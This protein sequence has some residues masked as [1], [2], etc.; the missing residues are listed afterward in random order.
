MAT[1]TFIDR[2]RT[3][4]KGQ[5]TG[6]AMEEVVAL[7]P[8]LTWNQVFLAIDDLSRS[9]EIRVTLDADR[10]YRIQ[11]HRPA[12]DTSAKDLDESTSR[13]VVRC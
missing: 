3:V 12:P 11:I 1:E 8:D 6:C 10:A 7:C 4:V 13:C 5:S 2:V 9:G